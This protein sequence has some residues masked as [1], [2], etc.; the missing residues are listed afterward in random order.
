MT[1]PPVAWVTLPSNLR[2]MS[3]PLIPKTLTD[4]PLSFAYSPI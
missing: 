4:T 3:T 2:L 1:D